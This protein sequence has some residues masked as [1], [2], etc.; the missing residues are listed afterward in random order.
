L[1]LNYSEKFCTGEFKYYTI[2]YLFIL[3]SPQACG[4][5]KRVWFIK[6]LY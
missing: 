5:D 2:F 6:I 1:P 4:E 3:S